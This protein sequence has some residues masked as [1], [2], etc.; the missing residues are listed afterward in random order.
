MRNI[1][2]NAASAFSLSSFFLIL[3]TILL[4]KTLVAQ[5][6]CEIGYLHGQGY[7][8]D[9]QSVTAVG[10]DQF[11]I[12]LSLKHDNCGP[13][14]CKKINHYAV[15]AIPGT[16]SNVSAVILSGSS[17]NPNINLGPNIGGVPFQIGRAHV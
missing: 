16:Y 3:F 13:P 14:A 11:I 8:T 15:Q 9:I 10:A 17:G 6:E 7:T 1:N 2:Y 12:V 4:S 5:Q